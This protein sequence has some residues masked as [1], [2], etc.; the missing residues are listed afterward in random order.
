MD[1]L[2][3]YMNKVNLQNLIMHLP[4]K[5]SE[6]RRCLNLRLDQPHVIKLCRRDVYIFKIKQTLT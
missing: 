2:N 3:M 6:F 5:I 1:F 4:R